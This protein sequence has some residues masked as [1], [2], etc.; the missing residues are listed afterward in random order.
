MRKLEIKF[1]QKNPELSGIYAIIEYHGEMPAFLPCQLLWQLL[2]LL[3]N[4]PNLFSRVFLWVSSFHSCDGQF[5]ASR[6][7]PWLDNLFLLD[8]FSSRHYKLKFPGPSWP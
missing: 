1:L 7:F 4:S 6:A 3:L 8:G 2:F 5:D